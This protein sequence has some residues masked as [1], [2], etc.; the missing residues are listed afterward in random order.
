LAA[1]A[2]GLSACATVPP[3]NLGVVLRSD[4]VAPEPLVEGSHVVSPWSQ[5][6]LYDVRVDEHTE[7]LGAISADGTALEAKASV[8]TFHAAPGELV[9]LAREVGPNFYAM[10]VL[11]IVS[12]TVRRVVAGLRADQL[13]TAG[14]RRAQAMVT[15]A[16]AEQLR[17]FHIIVDSVDLRALNV[18]FTSAAYAAVV[19]TG[20][21]EQKVY[22]ARKQIELAK[23]ENDVLRERARGIATA[24]AIVAPTLTPEVLRDD[25]MRA[26]TRLLTAPSCSVEF[27]ASNQN[28]MTEVSP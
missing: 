17:P 8:L 18:L 11:P 16:A 12:S 28:T 21:E 7:D 3:G 14:I 20:V 13:D 23:H 26:W 4:G 15:R 25:A 22:L 6:T 2:S 27:R 19:E 1:L 10:V 5:V 24:H 9:A